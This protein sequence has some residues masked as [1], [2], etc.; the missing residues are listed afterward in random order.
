VIEPDDV[1]PCLDAALAYDARVR[2]PLE[3]ARDRQ[4]ARHGR[5]AFRGLSWASYAGAHT[6]ASGARRRRSQER[7]PARGACEERVGHVRKRSL[8]EQP[9]ASRG[10]RGRERRL[11]LASEC[12]RWWIK[13][14]ML[15]DIAQ[16]RG[17]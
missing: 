11:Q 5:R 8:V 4:P 12:P 10:S 1:H 2:L 14:F 15:C 13:V 9:P 7:G 6:R 16:V 3:R 17:R